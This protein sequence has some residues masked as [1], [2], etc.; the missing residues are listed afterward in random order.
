M[1]IRINER[2]SKKEKYLLIDDRMRDFEKEKLQ[3]LG[4]RLIE[5]N[6]NNKLYP[7]IASH[8]DIHATKIDD[9]I[10]LEKD[11]YSYVIKLIGKEIKNKLNNKIVCGNLSL[12]KRYPYDIAYNVCSIGKKVVHNFK[13]TDKKVMDIIKEKGL[14]MIDIKQGYSKCSIAVIDDDFAILSDKTIANR[15]NQA[16]IETLVIDVDDSIKLLGEDGKYSKMH[17]FIGAK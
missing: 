6:K 1:N 13:Y 12:E 5:I 11:I 4:Y 10:V 15:L 2:V 17:G 14:E 7:E 9:T 16:N 8:V 3:E